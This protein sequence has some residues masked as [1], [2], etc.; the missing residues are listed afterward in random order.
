M[1]RRAAF[2]LAAVLVACNESPEPLSP[3]DDTVTDAAHALVASKAIVKIDQIDMGEGAAYAINDNGVATGTYTGGPGDQVFKWTKAGGMQFPSIEGTGH[4][5]NN[6]GDISGTS[7]DHAFLYWNLGFTSNLGTLTGGNDSDGYALN[8]SRHVVGRSDNATHQHAFRWINPGPMQDIHS[9]G[10]QPHLYSAARGIN[11]TDQ[12]VGWA[13]NGFMKDAFLWTSGIGA[14]V[15]MDYG[16]AETIAYDINESGVVVGRAQDDDGVTPFGLYYAVKWTPSG[17]VALSGPGVYKNAAMGIN[18]NGYVVGVTDATDATLWKPNGAAYALANLPGG[19][20]AVAE[21]VNIHLEIVGHGLATDF[22]RHA[23]YWKITFF[24]V[25]IGRMIPKPKPHLPPPYITLGDPSP[26]Q[27]VVLSD[28]RFNAA[29]IDPARFT[30]GDWKGLDVP[31]MRDARG[32]PVSARIDYDRDGDLDL[33]LSFDQRALEK[34][35][36]LNART[37]QLVLSADLG[38]GNGVYAVHEVKVVAGH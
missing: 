33:V 34:A 21:D 20:G 1:P 18:N 10:V 24:S 9:F 3:A 5:I 13:Q 27:F 36:E 32:T 16:G 14:T 29:K 38:E 8:N 2:L 19:S 4:D 6:N 23:I 12:V 26:L 37:T 22:T 15:L 35:G 25:M 17:I 28:L 11:A 30:L 7:G 31:V